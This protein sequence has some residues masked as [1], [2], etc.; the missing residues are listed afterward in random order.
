[1]QIGCWEW[2][3]PDVLEAIF[4]GID[5]DG[6][7]D[8]KGEKLSYS[9]MYVTY[10]DKLSCL[11]TVGFAAIGIGKAHADSQFTFSGH[12]PLKPFD[13]TLLLAYA[14]KKRAE[15]APGVGKSTDIIVIGPGK[16]TVK[17]EDQHLM[18]LDKIY[19]KSRRA[20]TKGVEAAKKETKKFVERVK[21]EYQERTKK[22][23]ETKPSASQTSESEP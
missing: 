18:E 17:A 19:Q 9:Q 21:A 3:F 2:E 8:H 22:E 13:E 16:S 23:A 4:I 12:W 14:A 20:S 7:V 1:L 5:D 10:Y 6:P 11:N 15:A